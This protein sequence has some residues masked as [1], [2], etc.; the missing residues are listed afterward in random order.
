[1]LTVYYILSQNS[2]KPQISKNIVF[3]PAT[4]VCCYN[5]STMC[6]LFPIMHPLNTG[7]SPMSIKMAEHIR[8][9]K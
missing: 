8:P 7:F 3:Q 5:S 4:A 6:C 1:M 9:V 2:A